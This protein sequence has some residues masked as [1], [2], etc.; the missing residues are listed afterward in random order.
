MEEN[1]LIIYFNQNKVME[2]PAP[3]GSIGL[4][5]APDN[6]IKLIGQDIRPY[7]LVIRRRG[8]RWFAISRG[9]GKLFA[10]NGKPARQ[11]QLT[12][13][14]RVFF[15]SYSL[16]ISR[17]DGDE[18]TSTQSVTSHLPAA[19]ASSEIHLSV[20]GPDA[21][22][23]ADHA[24]SG[25]RVSI[26]RDG[27]NHVVL[28]DSYCS[29]FHAVIEKNR[30]GWFIMDMGSKNGLA[31]D[32]RKVTGCRLHHGSQIAIGRTSILC[33][34][35]GIAGDADFLETPGIKRLLRKAGL[36]ARSDFPVLITGESGTGKELIAEHLHRGSSRSRQAY[37]P[38][39]CGAI[40]E[41]LADS[42]IFGHRKG[43]FTGAMENHD[44][45]LGAA[46]GGTLL[47]D[48]VGE[49]PLTLQAKLLR[50]L[51]RGTYTQVGDTV[52]R[53][54][55]VRVISS[56]NRDLLRMVKDGTFREDLYHRLAVLNLGL[57]PLRERE[58][59][60]VPLATWM[61]G[62]YDNCEGI[63][64]RALRKLKSYS[65]P[66]NVR[67]LRN[68]MCKAFMN[69]AGGVI[70]CEHVEF[71]PDHYARRNDRFD[72]PAELAALLESCE[73]KIA[74]AARKACIPRTTLRYRMRKHGIIIKKPET[75]SNINTIDNNKLIK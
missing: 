40:P 5:A 67:E 68:V 28:H 27:S 75:K 18:K 49:L 19:S 51:D 33:E 42:L 9:N 31:V 45:F 10:D 22:S 12:P 15:G 58:E 69:A 64:K 46:D 41:T 52:I 39:N 63:S 37:I 7:H 16:E 1:T 20:A 56:T 74:S 30:G 57:P 2:I 53:K 73:W 25:N 11:L 54:A 4:G 38:L 3:Y 50:M 14:G 26:G 59:D 65:W 17:A 43:A 71:G 60:I 34:L 23:A 29:S 24:F 70:L 47:L 72:D 48:E 61:A 21:R 44:G 8:R 6:D 55:D 32:G 13:R 62:R 35:P 66:G 36:Y